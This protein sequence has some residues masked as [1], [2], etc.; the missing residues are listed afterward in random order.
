[1]ISMN[2]LLNDAITEL[3]NL[4]SGE[5][6]LVKELFKGYVWKR[7]GKGERLT[8]GTL[9]INEVKNN[10][11]LGITVLDK[12]TSNQQKYKKD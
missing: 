8:L 12:T 1:M 6:F 11:S 7:L 3:V 10:P 2:P 4:N 5:V 9:F